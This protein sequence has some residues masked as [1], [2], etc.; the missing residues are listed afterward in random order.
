MHWS[1]DEASILI[2]LFHQHECLWNIKAADHKLKNKKDDAWRMIFD[3]F[4]EQ[5]PN[6]KLV[7]TD[8]KNKIHTLKTQFRKE[9]N[10]EKNSKSSG[11][12]AE[13]VS[14]PKLWCFDH[15]LFLQEGECVRKSVSSFEV[16][17]FLT[18]LWDR[19]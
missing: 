17:G 18:R 8:L 6:S 14:K 11:A 13:E 2:T 15:L 9:L 3:N 10:S 12:G 4:K 1:R 5:K 7:L 16:S 19:N